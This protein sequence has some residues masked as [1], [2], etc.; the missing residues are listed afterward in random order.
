MNP[1][2]PRP[3]FWTYVGAAFRWH[4][5]LLA[6]G[7]GVALAFLSGQPG[8]VLPLTGAAEILYL[9]MLSTPPRFRRAID[10]RRLKS[11]STTDRDKE[12][13]TIMATLPEADARRFHE[14]RER[15]AVLNRLA[16]QFRNAASGDDTLG[17]LHVD[18]LERLL[19][20]FLKLLYSKDAIT[21]FLDETDRPSLTAEIAECEQQLDGLRNAGGRGSLVRS[22]DDKLAT[23]RQ[24]LANYDASRENLELIN[25]ELD[26]IEQKI[27]A[28]SEMS[29]NARDPAAISAQVNGIAD[30]ITAT[31]DAIR[32]LDVVPTLQYDDAPAFLKDEA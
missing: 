4:W 16:R 5:N 21:R 8:V 13:D 29:L 19:W 7:A 31:T 25:A 17:N 27:A 3:G 12:L 6:V 2:P 1:S 9:G 15:C 11:V 30:S 22:L 24:R 10:A 32:T 20:I 23:M 18:S 28:V 14:L 26:R